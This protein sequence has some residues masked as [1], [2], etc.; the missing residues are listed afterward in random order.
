MTKDQQ[1]AFDAVDKI[2]EELY[3]KYSK[4]DPNNFNYDSLDRLPIVSITIAGV[5]MFIGLSIPSRN[6]CD[7]PEFNLYHSENNDRIYYEKSNTYESYY[8]YIKR[9]FREIKSELE[10]IKI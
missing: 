3:N 4:K 7:I 2:N 6:N 8:K 5:Y 9:K 10:N 1:E